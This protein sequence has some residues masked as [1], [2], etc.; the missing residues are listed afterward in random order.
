MFTDVPSQF[1][2]IPEEPV[3]AVEFRSSY[4]VGLAVPWVESGAGSATPL[5]LVIAVGGS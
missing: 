1:L 2:A 4:A 5:L 3:R